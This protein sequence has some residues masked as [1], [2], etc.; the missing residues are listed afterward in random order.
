MGQKMLAFCLLRVWLNSLPE[1]PSLASSETKRGAIK[2][3]KTR[4]SEFNIIFGFSS[5]FLKNHPN[6]PGVK[7]KGVFLERDFLMNVSTDYPIVSVVRETPT[8]TIP[9][10]SNFSVS[11]MVRGIYM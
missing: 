9:V 4:F 11:H 10:K 8:R 7:N 3:S 2:H 1:A 6:I 5:K